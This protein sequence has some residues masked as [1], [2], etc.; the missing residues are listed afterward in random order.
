MK[1]CLIGCGN[2][3]LWAH[4]PSYA[5]YRKEHPDV[6][7]AAC[8]D[9]DGARAEAMRARFGFERRYTDYRSML[10][11][12]RPDAVCLVVPERL[13]M[14]LSIEI[15]EQGFPLILEKPPGLTPD[16]TRRMLEAAE[17]SGVLHQVAF[18]RRFMPVVSEARER[19]RG[20]PVRSLS[21]DFFRVKRHESFFYTTA[22]HGIDT[23]RHLAGA[24]FARVELAY[25]E[26]SHLGEGVC[27]IYL[28]CLFENGTTATAR[29]CPSAGRL[30]E[31]HTVVG[32]D[33]T[34]DA[35]LPLGQISSGSLAIYEGGGEPT[36]RRP[37][38]FVAHV[39]NGFYGENAHF[40]DCVRGGLPTGHGLASALQSQLVA[41]CVRRRASL[42]E[43]GDF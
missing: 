33:L 43:K 18:N 25:Q 21:C 3:A 32:D 40:F 6:V 5:Q 23:L 28:S 12:E 24:D 37:D 38:P 15:M 10:A 2:M 41:D 11:N 36:V 19:F 13:T 29:F 8:C 22:I 17:K 14:P 9:V 7:L 16:E 26:L 39:E 42:Y 4:G 30:L 27:N 35:C 34:M 31:R 20:R 1:I